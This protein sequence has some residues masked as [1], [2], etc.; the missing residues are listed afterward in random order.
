MSEDCASEVGVEIKPVFGSQ[1]G[2]KSVYNGCGTAGGRPNEP[3]D[4]LIH[5]DKQTCEQRGHK[6]VVHAAQDPRVVPGLHDEVGVD[7][8]DVVHAP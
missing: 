3:V 1:Q 4:I 5:G 8:V 6:I 2:S 7:V